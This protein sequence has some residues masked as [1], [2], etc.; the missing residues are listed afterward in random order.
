MYVSPFS[1]TSSPRCLGPKPPNGQGTEK[2]PKKE[3]VRRPQRR[4]EGRQT[5][6]NI[7]TTMLR[8]Q[9]HTCHDGFPSLRWRMR[10]AERTPRPL[11]VPSGRGGS[12][13][14]ERSLRACAVSHVMLNTKYVYLDLLPS[15]RVYLRDTWECFHLCYV[16]PSVLF[17]ICVGTEDTAVHRQVLTE[18]QIPHLIAWPGLKNV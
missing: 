12:G 5:S 4:G 1:Q 14:N 6:N 8:K 17:T 2:S 10:L 9:C 3:T 11:P 15:L 16:T 13:L 18:G 7:K